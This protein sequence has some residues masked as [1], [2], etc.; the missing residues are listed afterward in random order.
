[1][2]RGMI[3][4]H[5]QS[6]PGMAKRKHVAHQSPYAVVHK[7]LSLTAPLSSSGEWQGVQAEQEAMKYEGAGAERAVAT[8]VVASRKNK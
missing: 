4:G 7:L 6:P 2:C 1:M 3:V 8:L 5:S